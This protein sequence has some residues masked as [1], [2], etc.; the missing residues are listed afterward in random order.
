MAV[1]D[2]DDPPRLA[3]MTPQEGSKD[4]HIPFDRFQTGLHRLGLTIAEEDER[5]LFKV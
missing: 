4:E 1:P 3:E 2:L 5:E